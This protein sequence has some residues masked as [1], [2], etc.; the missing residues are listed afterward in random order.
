MFEVIVIF[1]VP[2]NGV[3][4]VTDNVATLAVPDCTPVTLVKAK[5]RLSLW[6]V[7]WP[8]LTLKIPWGYLHG[9]TPERKCA[10]KMYEIVS[11]YSQNVTLEFYCYINTVYV[12]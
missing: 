9:I 2:A 1:L 8:M 10:G 4:W 5:T 12:Q 11:Y 7:I 6:A 3:G